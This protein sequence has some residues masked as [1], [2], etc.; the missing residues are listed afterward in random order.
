MRG[1][2]SPTVSVAYTK[3]QNWFDKYSKGQQ[4]DPEGYDEYGY[5]DNDVDRAGHNESEYYRNDSEEDEQDYNLAYDA[6]LGEWGFDGVK[7]IN[8]E[9]DRIVKLSK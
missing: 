9:L 6:A 4:Y 2:Y 3:D 8:N 7:P 5:D 1:K